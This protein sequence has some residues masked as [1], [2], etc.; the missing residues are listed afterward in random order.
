MLQV[1]HYEGCRHQLTAPFLFLWLL[2]QPLLATWNRFIGCLTR[3][4]P[5]S[6]HP[7]L[8]HT[9]DGAPPEVGKKGFK[10]ITVFRGTPFAFPHCGIRVELNM[11]EFE[12]KKI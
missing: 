7:H 9:P 4:D 10:A 3:D 5:E 11:R 12:L 1:S 2:Y 6:P 8:L